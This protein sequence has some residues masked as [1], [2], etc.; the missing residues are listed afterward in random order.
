[1]RQAK[2]L[3][4]LPAGTPIIMKARPAR[5]IR[6]GLKEYKGLVCSYH[7]ADPTSKSWKHKDPHIVIL[8]STG[9][10]FSFYEEE[11]QAGLFWIMEV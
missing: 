11:I 4:D 10:K 6:S 9:K 2:T 1:M 8:F 7:P 5:I 3:K